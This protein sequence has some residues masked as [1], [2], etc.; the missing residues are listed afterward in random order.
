[1][2]KILVGLITFVLSLSA[3]EIYATFNVHAQ[4]SANLAFD[5][6]GIV[7]KVNVDISSKVKQGDIL[8]VLENSDIEAMLESAKTTLKY[9]K[10]D[11]ERQLK[12][13]NLIDESKF[14]AY[15][16]QYENAKNQLAYQQALYNKT[17][18]KAPFDGVIF[19]KMIE[20]GDTVS[21]MML[22]TVFQLQSSNERKLVLE[23]DQKYW[24]TVKA[25]QTFSYSVDGDEKVYKGVLYKVY[26]HANNDNRKLRAE[27]K[28]DSFIVGLFGDGTILVPDTK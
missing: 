19:E 17:F 24:K 26:P 7:R 25:G 16:A 3:G 20:V 1:M 15:A 11:Y 18:L 4:Q 22:K 14:D 9:A 28:A 13:K 12:I 23:F 8:A 5:A 10:L 27:V 21:G 2:R 6:S